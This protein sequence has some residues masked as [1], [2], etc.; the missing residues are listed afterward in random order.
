MDKTYQYW[1]TLTAATL[2]LILVLATG[3]MVSSNR[4]L[5]MQVAERSRTIDE[6][7]RLSQLNSQI[8]QAMADV[9]VSQKDEQIRNL[10]SEHGITITANNEN[11][12]GAAGNAAGAAASENRR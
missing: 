2:S 1:V 7:M 9:A 5:Q 11:A 10:L 3:M 8:A 4:V 12:N 6:G